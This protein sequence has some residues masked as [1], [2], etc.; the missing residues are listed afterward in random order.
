MPSLKS[1]S[2]FK[3]LFDTVESTFDFVI[4]KFT[5]P[6]R[7]LSVVAP[8]LFNE[9]ESEAMARSSSVEVGY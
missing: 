1:Y 7:L 4:R 9:S 2:K 8:N 6:E 3:C 5:F